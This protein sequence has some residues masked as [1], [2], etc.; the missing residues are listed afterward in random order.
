MDSEIYHPAKFHH[1]MSTHAGDICYQYPADRMTNRQSD[2]QTVNDISPTCLSA[3]G[4]NNIIT[5]QAI[6]V[7]LENI[8]LFVPPQTYEYLLPATIQ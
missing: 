2:K 5:F 4:D 8:H 1:P 7:T 3:C 6:P